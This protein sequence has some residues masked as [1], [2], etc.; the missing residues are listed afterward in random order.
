M[1]LRVDIVGQ[2]P[3]LVMLHGWGLNRRVWGEAVVADLA[4]DFRLHLVDLPGHGRSSLPGE[5]FT[6]EA[7]CAELA[8]HLPRRAHWLGWS[9]GGLVS[10]HMALTRPE[11]IGRLVLVACNPCFVRAPGWP[12][13]MAPEVLAQFAQGLERDYQT[14][15]ARFLMLQ[16]KGE[17]GA[18]ETVRRLRQ[19]VLSEGEPDLRALRGGLRVL[20]QTSLQQRLSEVPSPQLW[21][22]GR[23]DTL[24]PV[25]LAKV[26]PELAPQARVEVFSAAAHAPFLSHGERFALYLRKFLLDNG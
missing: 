9:L 12:H 2:G 5:G 24:V 25:S 15:L 20:R 16:A 23:L 19:Q 7:V 13:G 4:A 14:T 21:L 17:A 11:R 8:A 3:E 10:L 26:L 22:L 18:R 1:T 6:L